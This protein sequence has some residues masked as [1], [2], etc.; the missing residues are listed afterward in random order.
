LNNA[1]TSVLIARETSPAAPQRRAPR[2]SI[3]IRDNNDA[4]ACW[5]NPS[6]SES[7]S[8]WRRI[9]FA[10]AILGG[11]LEILDGP[12]APIGRRDR[13][14]A[15]PTG[16]LALCR[17]APAAITESN[18][19]YRRTHRARRVFQRIKGQDIKVSRRDEKRQAQP[20][21]SSIVTPRLPAKPGRIP[22]H[23]RHPL[24]V[25]SPGFLSGNPCRAVNPR[26]ISANTATIARSR[27]SPLNGI[28]NY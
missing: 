2:L 16:T 3:R 26:S 28:R 9:S 24:L 8:L 15:R 13:L 25:V 27:E 1:L 10:R 18:R 20:W 14:K 11:Y 12:L 17:L 21:T 6:E 23:P 7:L 22:R 5:I 4:F 19:T